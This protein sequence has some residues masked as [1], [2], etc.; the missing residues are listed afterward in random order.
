MTILDDAIALAKLGL[1]VFPLYGAVAA[2]DGY[3]CLCGKL[4]CGAKAKHPIR[5]GGFK[6]ASRDH[7][8]VRNFFDGE[9]HLNI[10]VAT[11]GKIIVLDIDAD[12]GRENLKRLEADHGPLPDTW[13]VNTGRGAHYYFAPPSGVS[14]ANSAGQ[15]LAGLDIRGHG[16]YV[17][18]VG[19]THISGRRYTWLRS[20]DDAPLAALPDWLASLAV[21]PT[22]ASRKPQ[23]ANSAHRPTGAGDDQDRVW[24]RV[25][26]EQN[27]SELAAA[28][29]GT[30]NGLLNAKA[31]RSGRMI[32]GGLLERGVVEH[33]LEQAAHDCDLVTDRRA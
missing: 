31:F 27:C 11:G 32:G 23:K 7:A 26:L 19:S 2:D 9:Q 22:R 6:G 29:P 4:S 1:E 8:I 16:G 3:T 5:K 33:A 18:G 12:E 15:V 14:I 17:V 24:A 20:P 28:K 30:R 10:G 25:A 21:K 13:T